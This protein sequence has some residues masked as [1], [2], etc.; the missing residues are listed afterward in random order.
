MLWG[1]GRKGP[2][3]AV[4]ERRD[5][6]IGFSRQGSYSRR[7]HSSSCIFPVLYRRRAVDPAQTLIGPPLPGVPIIARNSRR[8]VGSSR[9]APS[10]VLVTM[11]TPGLWTPR[12]V[13]H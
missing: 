13:M 9:K 11:L 10:M 12:V 6:S 5:S 8:V 3:A 2:N 4:G 7:I 1:S